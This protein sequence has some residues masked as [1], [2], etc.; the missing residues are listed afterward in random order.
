MSDYTPPPLAMTE[1]V[2]LDLSVTMTAELAARYRPRLLDI[3]EHCGDLTAEGWDARFAPLSALVARVFDRQESPLQEL[4][5]VVED[6]LVEHFTTFAAVHDPDAGQRAA[7][8]TITVGQERVCDV[9]A[10]D[11][12]FTHGNGV[13]RRGTRRRWRF[14]YEV[15]KN[16]NWD[17]EVVAGLGVPV[18]DLD[19][20]DTIM[21]VAVDEDRAEGGGTLQDS[22]LRFKNP[23][24]LVEFQI[25]H[26]S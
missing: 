7:R 3:L 24:E 10:G 21:R 13:E 22:Y 19:E 8:K 23:Y 25:A 1:V 20:R 6:D 4:A 11:V 15:W 16:G 2:R 12:V 26:E 5:Q 18:D 9:Q 17:D 14:V